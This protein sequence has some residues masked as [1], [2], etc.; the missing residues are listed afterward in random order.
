MYIGLAGNG[1]NWD[2]GCTATAPS[3]AARSPLE[4]WT[5]IPIPK[6]A[7]L[8]SRTPPRLPH[9]TP[10]P[11][12]GPTNDATHAAGLACRHPP[13]P[14]SPRYKSEQL[15]DQTR[16]RCAH[17]RGRNLLKVFCLLPMPREGLGVTGSREIWKEAE[18]TM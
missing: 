8:Y 11:S 2:A 4:I 15:P 9:P 10:L 3:S 14:G 1:P 6:S 17:Q 12:A 18:K 7:L 5:S 13:W 16:R